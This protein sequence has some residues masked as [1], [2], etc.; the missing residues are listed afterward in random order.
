[1]NLKRW[2]V[3]TVAAFVAIW[4][5]DFYIH[6]VWL[7]PFYHAHAAWWRP[8]AQMQSLLPIMF[9]SELILAGLL[10]LVYAR[11]YELGKGTVSQGLRFGALVGLLLAL[12]RNLI[13]YVIY[14]YPGDLIVSWIVGDLVMVTLAGAIIGSIYKPGK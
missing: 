11:G 2:A 12:P 8:E 5:L 7:G 14:P 3:A 10:A 13:A 9:L 1:M 4:V 6:H